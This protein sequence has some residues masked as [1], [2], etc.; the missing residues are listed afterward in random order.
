MLPGLEKSW[1]FAHVANTLSGVEVT[2]LNDFFL[3]F[4]NAA[5]AFISNPLTVAGSSNGVT[6]NMS[7]TDL[8][9]NQASMVHASGAHSWIVLS[10]P[11]VGTNVQICFDFNSSNHMLADIVWSPTGFSGGS[12]T[13]RPTAADESVLWTHGSTPW[14]GVLG[15]GSGGQLRGHMMLSTDG[16]CFRFIIANAG[17]VRGFLLVDRAGNPAT[18]WTNPAI[19]RFHTTLNI[20]DWYGSAYIKAV[21]PLGA[22]PLHLIFELPMTHFASRLPVT[23]RLNLANEISGEYPMTRVGLWH[24]TAGQ[25]GRHGYIFDFFFTCAVLTNGDT[26]PA[27]GSKQFVVFGDVAF[28]G[29]GTD[30]ATG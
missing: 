24:N 27:D 20:A 26:M 19:A 7:G 2:D 13:A 5:K 14:V 25:K 4:K 29:D 3:R 17:N 1:Q 6:S 16:R 9:T 21:G 8:L 18:G 28:P 11:Q 23:E 30:W 15:T 12:T 22:M 10:L